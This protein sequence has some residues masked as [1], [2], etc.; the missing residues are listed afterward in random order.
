MPIE[1]NEQNRRKL[2]EKIVNAMSLEELT[3]MAFGDLMYEFEQDG[4]EEF[5]SSW[6][7]HIGKETP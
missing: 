6:Q 2:V 1:N 5:A 4:D 7:H 3:E